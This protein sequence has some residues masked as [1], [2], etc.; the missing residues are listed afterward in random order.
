MVCPGIFKNNHRAQDSWFAQELIYLDFDGKIT[1]EKVLERFD[2]VGIKPNFYYNTFSNSKEKPSFRIVLIL[3]R[4]ITDKGL[5]EK[6]LKGFKYMFP[7][8][9]SKC[10]ETARLFFG[11]TISVHLT[12]ERVCLDSLIQAVNSFCV[13]AANTNIYRNTI[14][15]NII[16]LNSDYP[17]TEAREN[18][19]KSMKDYD[20]DW[21]ELA[22]NCRVFKRF[23]DGEWLFHLQLFG[24]ATNMAN[25]G[26]GIEMYE[27]L[28]N[29]KNSEGKT[30][31]GEV[32]YGKEK[33]VLARMVNNMKYLPMNLKN[34]SEDE[35]DLKYKNFF[36]SVHVEKGIYEVINKDL[37]KEYIRLKQAQKEYD[38]II[39]QALDDKDFS[40]YVIKF[41]CGGGKTEGITGLENVQ[42][43]APYHD[44]IKE[45]EGRMKT[46]S[47]VV[48]GLPKFKLEKINNEIQSCYDRGLFGEANYIIDKIAGNIKIKGFTY[49]DNDIRLAKEYLKNKKY[50]SKEGEN[51]LST[52]NV[53]LFSPQKPIIIF[54]EDPFE[55]VFKTDIIL[56]HEIMNTIEGFRKEKFNDSLNELFEL[57]K[58]LEPGKIV[59]NIKLTITND[60]IRK[61]TSRSDIGNVFDFLFSDSF[62]IDKTNDQIVKYQK[63]NRLRNDKT[64]V[65]LSATPQIE[66]YR[67]M[68]GDRVKFF[69]L[70]NVENKGRIIQNTDYS[71]SRSSF[72]KYDLITPIKAEIG[73]MP[74]ITFKKQRDEFKDNNT[75]LYFGKLLGLNN[76]ADQD[77]AVLGTPYLSEELALL[78]GWMIGIDVNGEKMK[79]RKI[80]YNNYFFSFMTYQNQDLQRL[81]LSLIENQNI[82]ATGRNRL[83]SYNR[84]T[85]L[86]SSLPL[87]GAILLVNEEEKVEDIEFEEENN[88][89]SVKFENKN[90]ELTNN[91]D[92]FMLENEENE[93]KTA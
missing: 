58:G 4:K 45:I 65:I 31:K 68:Y 9:D 24:I 46:P 13:A 35:E 49:T 22:N 60:D 11:G 52:H 91:N 48:R 88:I 77:I 47:Y 50:E 34:F 64:Y 1:I 93:E 36:H 78:Y 32:Y 87:D 81:H 73:N 66:L 8:A 70:S 30:D 82:Q 7:Q 3:D 71:Y 39:K 79:Y 61:Y 20:I 17:T 29:K 43:T 90:D 21:V 2:S 33:F 15:P 63:H 41:V 5:C 76:F 56:K 72:E 28:I 57:L 62:N 89:N 18:Y 42:I 44:L 53:G 55:L 27:F 74:V 16:E 12:Y 84:T 40:I 6:L 14:D 51:I 67:K 54:D 69:D 80:A 26:G 19:R 86:Y 59:D 37:K 92:D 83:V 23:W 38:E 25:L 85:F 10:M 75:D